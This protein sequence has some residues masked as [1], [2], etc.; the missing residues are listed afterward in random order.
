VKLNKDLLKLHQNHPQIAIYNRLSYSTNLHK[1]KL[2]INV[3][4]DI[5]EVYNYIVYKKILQK[6]LII[7]GLQSGPKIS[8]TILFQ[9][10]TN[11]QN[12]SINLITVIGYFY[13]R[14]RLRAFSKHEKI[15]LNL[16]HA[17]FASIHSLHP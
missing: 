9:C 7:K 11:F 15:Y 13:A 6:K 16:I 8:A 17:I 10:R 1:Y 2:N 12:K 3:N 4:G 5:T 14:N